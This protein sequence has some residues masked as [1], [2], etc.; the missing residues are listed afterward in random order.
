MLLSEFLTHLKRLKDD[1]LM[2]LKRETSVIQADLDRVNKIIQVRFF[3]FWYH[4][5][6]KERPTIRNCFVMKSLFPL[7]YLLIRIWRTYTT[8]EHEHNEWNT[9]ACTRISNHNLLTCFFLPKHYLCLLGCASFSSI[10]SPLVIETTGLVTG[11]Q[12]KSIQYIQ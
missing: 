5:I 6:E 11:K 9:F 4:I 7:K 10:T 3:M 12:S 1:Q 8:Y 2:Q